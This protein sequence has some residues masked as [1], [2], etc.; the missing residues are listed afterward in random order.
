MTHNVLTW[1]V[2]ETPMLLLDQPSFQ[3]LAIESLANGVPLATSTG[4]IVLRPD[5]SPLLI[6][7]WHVITGRRPYTR[8]PLHSSGAVPNAL[9][10]RHNVHEMIGNWVAKTERLYDKSG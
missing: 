1:F 3:S 5:G 7:N 10:I 6:T 8:Q 4:F 9:R 2:A